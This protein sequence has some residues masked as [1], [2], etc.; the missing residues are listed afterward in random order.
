MLLVAALV[1]Q[2]NECTWATGCCKRHP[3]ACKA[4]VTASRRQPQQ[5]GA[6]QSAEADRTEC[7]CGGNTPAAAHDAN[8]SLF[9]T[10]ASKWGLPT[11]PCSGVSTHLL[12]EYPLR[13]AEWKAQG[14]IF[15]VCDFQPLRGWGN[16]LQILPVALVIAVLLDLALV[17]DCG[18][19]IPHNRSLRELGAEAFF[20][21]P[22]FD[23]HRGERSIPPQ[24][25]V[26]L[27]TDNRPVNA[28]KVAQVLAAP[29]RQLLQARPSAVAYQAVRFVPGSARTL[30]VADDAFRR[31]AV[32]KV[33]SVAT[34]VM[35]DACLFR[36]LLAPSQRA[37][38]QLANF[39]L[40]VAPSGLL[41][42][43]SAHVRLLGD[44]SMTKNKR[45]RTV[46]R[47]K[48]ISDLYHKSPGSLFQCLR[49][50]SRIPSAC[51]R[52]A[53]VT[54]DAHV[55]KGARAHLRGRPSSQAGTQCTRGRIRP[56]IS[57]TATWRRSMLTGGSW[58]CRTPCCALPETRCRARFR[59]RPR[60][61]S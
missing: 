33:G 36:Y 37:I 16:Y 50:H 61:V 9:P 3:G 28:S 26:T 12:Q 29:L 46:A 30:L 42:L 22:H 6:K 54:D 45:A 34:S 32:Q 43:A 40:P 58:P 59:R 10:A 21:G 60:R 14:R 8:A 4:K 27:R 55:E 5:R 25:M 19:A 15:Y 17:L 57:P 18:N 53:I 44:P 23:W 56:R 31:H 51:L 48:M 1:A 20:A 13:H 52:C 35:L 24:N 2:K 49:S 11:A 38:D 39:R 47:T 7:E 41:R